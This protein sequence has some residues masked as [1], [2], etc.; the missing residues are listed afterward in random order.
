MTRNRVRHHFLDFLKK[1]VILMT[2]AADLRIFARDFGVVASDLGVSASDLDVVTS[3]LGVVTCDLGAAASDLGV[4]ADD[5]GVGAS[6]RGVG[7]SDLGVVTGDL[8]FSPVDNG[9]GAEVCA[10][11]RGFIRRLRRL[12]RREFERFRIQNSELTQVRPL[13]CSRGV[14]ARSRRPILD[15]CRTFVLFKS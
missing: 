11:A 12:R 10:G 13:E 5:L 6:D 4:V 1:S 7:A 2:P 15:S 3:D 8:G 14:S 9:I